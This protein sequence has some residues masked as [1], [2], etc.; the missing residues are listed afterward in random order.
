MEREVMGR[1]EMLR[2]MIEGGEAW[3]RGRGGKGS[4]SEGKKC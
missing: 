3:V 4:Q 1:E 2:E